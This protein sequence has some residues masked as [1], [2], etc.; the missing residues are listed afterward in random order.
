M[1]KMGNAVAEKISVG[2]LVF[3]IIYLCLALAAVAFLVFFVIRLIQALKEP[4][5]FRKHSSFQKPMN[6]TNQNS[7]VNN[8]ASMGAPYAPELETTQRL[9]ENKD[10]IQIGLSSVIGTR[11]YQQDAV[12]ATNKA[13]LNKNNFKKGIVVLCDGMGGMNGGEIASALTTKTIYE[14]YLKNKPS[15]IP[16]F[17]KEE[18][19]KVDSLVYELKD[20]K[21]QPMGSGSTLI[22]I[23]LD[24]GNLFWV[25]VGDSRIYIIRNNEMVQVTED[26]NYFSVLRKKAESGLISAEE[27]ANDPK[28]EALISFIGIGKESPVDNNEQPFPLLDGDIILLCSDGLYKTLP[29][30]E[31]LRVIQRY[32]D[33]VENAAKMLTKTV[34]D[35]QKRG[36]DNTTV[37]VVKYLK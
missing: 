18:V 26:H 32:S 22:C 3:S 28:A 33:N 20:E 14:D 16:K 30:E 36:Q 37:A 7:P 2:N 31:I 1:D 15:D 29:D 25:S 27:A 5:S 12:V 9:F 35:K 21:N 34:L 10:K 8:N 24:N 11:K 23:V 17:L 19:K 4:D 6:M 13:F